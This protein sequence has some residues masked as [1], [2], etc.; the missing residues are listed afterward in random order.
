MRK[1]N[2]LVLMMVGGLIVLGA[3]IAEVAWLGF[4]FGTVIVGLLMLFFMPGL[5]FAPFNFGFLIGSP[6]FIAGLDKMLN[7]F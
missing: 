2:G 4:C 5:L 6:I 1:L 7:E 3:G